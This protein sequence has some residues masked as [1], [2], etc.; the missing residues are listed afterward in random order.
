MELLQLQYFLLLASQQHV[1]RTAE[2]LHI[3]QPAL[4]LTIKKLEAELGVP[5]LSARG[6][7]SPSPPT[8][9]RLSSTWKTP[10]SR[11]KT[12]SG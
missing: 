4:S 9:R 12:G 7:T 3:S 8:A 5:L 2:I 6:A 1:T 11:W 10:F